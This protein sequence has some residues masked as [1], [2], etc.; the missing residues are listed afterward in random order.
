VSWD[1]G[2][3]LSSYGIVKFSILIHPP[4]IFSRVLDAGMKIDK[5]FS[6]EQ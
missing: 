4:L 1:A 6:G 2:M 3:L 5:G